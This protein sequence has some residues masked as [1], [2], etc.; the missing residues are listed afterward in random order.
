MRRLGF[1]VL[2]VVPLACALSSLGAFAQSTEPPERLG[3]LWAGR[4]AGDSFTTAIHSHLRELGR[5][6]GRN[7]LIVNRYAEGDAG[8]CVPQFQLPREGAIR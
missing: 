7:L 4:A 3:F 1:V 6:E 8:R 2:G 5:M